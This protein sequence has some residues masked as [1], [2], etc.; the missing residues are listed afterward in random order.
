YV[1][2]MRGSRLIRWL[3]ALLGALIALCP[4]SSL[5]AD[6]EF[7]RW[8]EQVWPEASAEG[9]TR[10]TFE[11]ATAELG[12][13]LSLPDLILPGKPPAEPG[14]GQVEF[15]KP[16]AEYLAEASL[17]RLTEQGRKLLATHA[18]TLAA[19]EREFGV[20]PTVLVA[21][22]GRET[23]YGSY[24]LPHNAIRVLATQGYVGRRK[25]MFRK[26]F[27]LG[28]KMLQEGHVK[29]SDMRSSWAGAMGLTQFL[30][31]DFYRFGVD[32]DRDGRIDLWTSVPDALASA[33]K[34][35]VVYGWQAGKPW[36]YEVRVPNGIDCTMADAAIIRSADEW[37]RMG[38]VP[39]RGRRI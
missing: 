19:I 27:V 24:R 12:P 28:L 16:P 8:L 36:A 11:A 35:L 29:L 15:L 2:S 23:A 13:D 30:P 10:A 25:D 32:F 14:R 5:R 6:P 3:G 20:P 26:E 31:S 21:L 34:Q 4:S 39:A 9:V 1:W 18:A 38:V 17:A 33:A 37:L 22:W 7:R